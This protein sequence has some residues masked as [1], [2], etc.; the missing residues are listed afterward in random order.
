MFK[1]EEFHQIA[2]GGVMKIIDCM[3]AE[4]SRKSYESLA[5]R[6]KERGTDSL[7]LGCTEVGMLLNAKIVPKQVVGTAAG[8]PCEGRGV[9][10]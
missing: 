1:P 8:S 5:K 4:T 7:I 2:G 3:G 6:L 9:A 10:P